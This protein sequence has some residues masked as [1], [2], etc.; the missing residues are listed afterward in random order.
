MYT[1]QQFYAGELLKASQLEAMED[2]IIEAQEMAANGSAVDAANMEM[3]SNEGATQQIPDGVADG[4]DFSGKNTLAIT[5]DPELDGVIPYGATGKYSAAFGG[6]SAAIG[7]RSHSEGSTTIAKGAYTHAEGCDSVALGDASHV[8]GYQTTTSIDAEFGH[9]EGSYTGVD[10]KAAH[11]EGSYSIAIGDYS[12]AEGYMTVAEGVGSH[13][14][15]YSDNLNFETYGSIE[16]LAEAWALG[17]GFSRA[18][19]NASHV[20][21]SNCLAIGEDSHAEG[22]RNAAVGN[23]SHA[24][25][26]QNM[27]SGNNS[28]ASGYNNT[29]YYDNQ[30]VCGLYNDNKEEDLFEVGNG[31]VNEDGAIIHSNAF[32]VLKDGRARVGKGPVDE[33]DVVTLAYLTRKIK[34]LQDQIDALKGVTTVTSEE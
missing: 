10:G 18:I 6:K 8:E 32:A 7:K 33:N 9:A 15:G 27:A 13:A 1:K 28:H 11:A 20:E 26:F 4:I 23:A 25:G 3:G 5:V 24:E 29:I 19:G 12:H 17:D 22:N 34:E 21:G 16:E 2:G 14:E 31:Y 30:Y